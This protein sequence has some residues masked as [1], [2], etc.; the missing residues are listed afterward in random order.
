MLRW[1][2]AT[3]DDLA[4]LEE[5]AKTEEFDVGYSNWILYYSI[6]PDSFYVLEDC[7]GENSKTIVGYLSRN[8]IDE[9][10][11]LNHHML[12]LPPYRK[13]GIMQSFLTE[14]DRDWSGTI[15]SNA[16]PYGARLIAS[17]DPNSA[18]WR[19]PQFI[20]Y[21]GSLLP[22]RIHFSN[23]NN[24]SVQLTNCDLLAVTK[25]N[26]NQVLD[27]DS[28]KIHPTCRDAFLTSWM[29]PERESAAA[30]LALCAMRHGTVVGYGVMRKISD[31]YYDMAPVYADD[32]AVA[33]GLMKQLCAWLVQI[34]GSGVRIYY[35]FPVDQK[36][37]VR[38]AEELGLKIEDHETRIY[39][40]ELVENLPWKHCYA[41]HQFWLI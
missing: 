2:L 17:L 14:L 40:R 20:G 3:V 37:S 41:I 23:N 12:I 27:Y 24:T 26:L 18:L 8:K 15:V 5:M 28:G 32:D 16:N 21:F 10:T 33:M 39:Q 11:M 25:E 31:T 7:F 4:R 1:R 35:A 22:D 19:G 38:L 30:A 9:R 36:P 34:A 6:S 13:A 29:I